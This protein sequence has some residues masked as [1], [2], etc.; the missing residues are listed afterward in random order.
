[1]YRSETGQAREK[2]GY[3]CSVS[4][5]LWTFFLFELISKSVLCLLIKILL[6]VAH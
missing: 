6:C 4:F 1:M 3:H 5:A 2:M